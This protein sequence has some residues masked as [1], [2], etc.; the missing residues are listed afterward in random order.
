MSTLASFMLVAVGTVAIASAANAQSGTFRPSSRQ[1]DYNVANSTPRMPSARERNY[2]P[3]AAVA[4]RQMATRNAVVQV[5]QSALRA[6]GQKA[7]A[8]IMGAAGA[9]P[10]VAAAT[11]FF[12]PNTA[13]APAIGDPITR[14]ER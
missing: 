3:E 5:S 9:N 13:Y 12:I 11:T 1:S 6:T 10:Y 4:A 2:V 14:G 8:E 7:A